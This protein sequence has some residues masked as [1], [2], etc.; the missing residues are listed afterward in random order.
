MK[1]ENKEKQL[2]EDIKQW[3]GKEQD[4]KLEQEII[5][6]CLQGEK[7]NCYLDDGCKGEQ[8]C[9]DGSWSECY[10]KKICQPNKKIPCNL[11]GCSFGYKT[12]NECGDGWSECL[13][14]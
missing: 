5:K 10:L 13:P 7:K 11:D 9:I 1:N 2:P 3:T 14:S 4:K 6:E 12:C 8:I